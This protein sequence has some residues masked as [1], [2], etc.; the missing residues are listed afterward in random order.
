[1]KIL[2]S[3]DDGVNALGIRTLSRVLAEFAEVVTVAPDRNRSGA[4]HS[5]TLEVPLRADK[6]DDTGFYSV[7]GTPTDCVH[8]AVNSL[9]DPDPDMVVAGINHGANLGDDVLY[10]GTVAAA[11]EGRHLG[12]PAVAVSLCGDRHFDTAAHYAALLVQGVLRAPLS[13]NQIL[14]VN[15]PDLPLAEIQG[16]K[17][18]RLG[19]RHRSEA[20]LKEFDPRG[21]PI[22]WIGPPG[23]KQ[24]AGEGTDFDAV[25]RGFVSIT[26]LTIDMTAYSQ[27][28][29][30]ASW[31]KEVE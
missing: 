13:A 29:A 18:T 9:L 6:L 17:V 11:T 7:K 16:I 15:I 12:L 28:A 30:L 5:L 22:Y 27:M 20:V 24:D 14:N 26:P 31:I 23:A 19:N 10:S 21:R 2:V 3:N 25:E 8:W 4:S 1:M